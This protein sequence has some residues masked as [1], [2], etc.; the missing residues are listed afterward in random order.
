MLRNNNFQKDEK[1]Q[2]P[3]GEGRDKSKNKSKDGA[4]INKLF[5]TQK[6]N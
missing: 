6:V 1:S 3:T 5:F 2:K 4:E